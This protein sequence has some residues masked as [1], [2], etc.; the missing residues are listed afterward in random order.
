[1][2]LKYKTQLK[3]M[4]ITRS[5]FYKDY[6]EQVKKLNIAKPFDEAGFAEYCEKLGYV[7]KEEENDFGPVIP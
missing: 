2:S 3:R 4:N 6:L 5:A 7:F 1:M